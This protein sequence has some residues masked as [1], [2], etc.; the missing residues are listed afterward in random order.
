MSGRRLESLPLGKGCTRL[1]STKERWAQPNLRVEAA[2][3]KSP[4]MRPIG[5]ACIEHRL[6]GTR[7]SDLPICYPGLFSGSQGARNADGMGTSS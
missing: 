7:T 1:G 2:P 6:R 4:P 3:D 5:L